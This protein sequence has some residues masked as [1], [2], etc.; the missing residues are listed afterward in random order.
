MTQ[1][2]YQLYSSRN[3]GP[4]GDTFRMLA[5]LGYAG[6]EGYGALFADPDAIRELRAAMDDTGLQMT[7]GHFGLDMVEEDPDA[8]LKIASDLGLAQVYVPHLAAELRPED[9]DGWEAFGRRLAAAGKPLQAAGL[10]FGWHNHD[11]EFLPLPDGSLPIEAIFAGGPD[12]ALEYDV[13]WAARAGQDAAHWLGV[14]ADRIM[15]AHIKDIAEAGTCEN[16]DGWSDVGQGMMDWAG[17][18][19]SLRNAGCK[20]FIAEHDNPSDDARFARRSL[21]FLKTV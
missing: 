4:L 14:F 19:A 16:E 13:A 6:V 15:A 17:L 21:D 18:M 12:L 3:F 8:A 10:T 5:D 7:S 1:Y 20:V 11:F 2:S 9:R